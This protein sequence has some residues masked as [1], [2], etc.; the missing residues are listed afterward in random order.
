MRLDGEVIVYH[1]CFYR[2]DDQE[3]GEGINYEEETTCGEETS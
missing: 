1:Y 3:K 2:E